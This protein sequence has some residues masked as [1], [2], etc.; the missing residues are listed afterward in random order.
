MK[1]SEKPPKK[2]LKKI[3]IAGCVVTLTA[4]AVVVDLEAP[5]VNG[6]WPSLDFGY[7]DKFHIYPEGKSGPA[8]LTMTTAAS[9]SG[10]VAVT[11]TTTT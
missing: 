10:E 4:H 7:H 3:V 2:S 11:T 9:S 5:P 1:S 8:K 6:I